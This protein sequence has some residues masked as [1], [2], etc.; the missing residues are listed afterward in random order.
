VKKNHTEGGDIHRGKPVKRK[1]GVNG[2]ISVGSWSGAGLKK[3][4]EKGSERGNLRGSLA[5][6][7]KKKSA[8]GRE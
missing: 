4:G 2:W 8:A 6:I 3:G 7:H 1:E 5:V